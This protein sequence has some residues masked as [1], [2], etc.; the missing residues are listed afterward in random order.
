MTSNGIKTQSAFVETSLRAG[1]SMAAVQMWQAHCRRLALLEEDTESLTNVML[2]L[3]DEAGI[4]PL[5]ICDDL[6]ANGVKKLDGTSM[7][8]LLDLVESHAGG[9]Y[10]GDDHEAEEED[11]AEPPATQ[12]LT[13]PRKEADFFEPKTVWAPKKALKRQLAMVHEEPE[14]SE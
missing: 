12:P 9:R 10:G 8:K 5:A 3:S 14:E 4:S 2:S 7:A 1:H 13:P 11:S 6:V